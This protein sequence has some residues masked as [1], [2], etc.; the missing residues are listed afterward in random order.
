MFY[1][2]NNIEELLKKSSVRKLIFI[3]T[4][5]CG[6]S[7]VSK[8]L[9]HLNIIN[10]AHTPAIKDEGI[11]FTIIRN[12]VERFE[13]LLN[14]RLCE[15]KP[16]GDWPKNLTYVYKDKNIT[17]NEIVSKMNDKQIV[18]FFPYK[19]LIYWTTNVDVII[20]IDQLPA[21]LKH[22]GYTY[23]DTL[24]TK[25]NV[26]KKSRGTFNDESVNKI[27]TL[28]NDDMILFNKVINSAF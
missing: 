10:K 15:Q 28:Y 2:I 14:Y 7:Y 8:I 1:T 11:N 19:T 4:P 9:A 22:F 13:S 12:P 25:I 17:L 26:S 6:G 27:T 21:L 20:T 3:H 18:S 23:D 5:K 24:F 16:R